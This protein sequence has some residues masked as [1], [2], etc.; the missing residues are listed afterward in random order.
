LATQAFSSGSVRTTREPEGRRPASMESN[1][2]LA[3]A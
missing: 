3:E 1:F 2:C